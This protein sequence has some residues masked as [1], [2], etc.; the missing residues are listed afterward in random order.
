MICIVDIKTGSIS[1]SQQSISSTRA[2][3]WPWQSSL[4]LPT[5]VLSCFTS[6]LHTSNSLHYSIIIRLY[7]HLYEDF[8]YDDDRKRQNAGFTF[9]VCCSTLRWP[10]W[11]WRSSAHCKDRSFSL[12]ASTSWDWT[13]TSCCS[14]H[15]TYNV[16]N[17]IHKLNK[18]HNPGKFTQRLL[19][20]SN[21][22]TYWSIHLVKWININV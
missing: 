6:R 10:S 21:Q 4:T 8:G 9:M 18:K 14:R 12:W 1:L 19:C 20:W 7:M 13:W 2:S 22:A 5:S 16:T 11:D 17:H 15:Q 3:I